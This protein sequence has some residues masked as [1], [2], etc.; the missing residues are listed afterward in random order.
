MSRVEHTLYKKNSSFSYSNESIL[1]LTGSVREARKSTFVPTES[2]HL[3]G[4]YELSVDTSSLEIH[5]AQQLFSPIVFSHF[6]QG[7]AKAMSDVQNNSVG[8]DEIYESQFNRISSEFKILDE[9]FLVGKTHFG[10]ETLN[11]VRRKVNVSTEN[12]EE[13]D[14]SEF[15]CIEETDFNGIFNDLINSEEDHTDE[16]AEIAYDFNKRIERANQLLQL[17]FNGCFLLLN[18]DET[19]L[20]TKYCSFGNDNRLNFVDEN[21]AHFTV[22]VQLCSVRDST[23]MQ[24]KASLFWPV[25]STVIAIYVISNQSVGGQQ[26]ITHI[27]ECIIFLSMPFCYR[28]CLG[29]IVIQ[30]DFIQ[31]IG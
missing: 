17:Y 31:G 29:Q 21:E 13:D 4:M 10:K 23:T 7:L 30:V 19:K 25:G 1:D 26:G 22:H 6:Y 12:N 5:Q 15:S 27:C 28:K 14:D 20:V 16:I 24:T 3:V 18:Y 11:A 2:H 9:H 8:H